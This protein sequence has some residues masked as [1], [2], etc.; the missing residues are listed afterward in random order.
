MPIEVHELRVPT[1]GPEGQAWELATTIYLPPPLA[2]ASGSNM[3][4]L[5]PGGGYGRG[6]F[7]LPV[8]GGSQALYHAG[9]GSIVVAV[10]PLG[11]GDSSA[12]EDASAG[13]ATAALN[14]A[15]TFISEGL[16]GGT[17]LPGLGPVA[18]GAAVGAGQSLGGH[19]LVATQAEYEPFAGIALLG[20]SMVGTR[21][22]LASGGST[23][24]TSEA[25]FKYVFH[26][27]E[28]PQ[29]DPTVAQT[30]LAGLA[31]VDVAI[32]LPVRHGD[33][34][35]ASRS[36]PSYVVELIDASA[37]K[38]GEV[39]GFVLVA[40]GERDVTGPLEEEAA[41]F[42]SAKGVGTFL[43]SEAAHMHNFAPSRELL[44]KQV[45][46]FVHHSTTAGRRTQSEAYMGRF[47]SDA[48]EEESADA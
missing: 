19:L 17:L 6:Y 14:A 47:S 22:P 39:T 41:T 33:A 12:A 36:F 28:V 34:S 24:S 42:T 18:F 11:V 2:L 29:V 13:A 4:V 5:L 10:D 37:A 27:G 45:D 31:G 1:P 44:W 21:F 40:A 30:D 38:A 20:S 16:R 3:L 48:D 15:V 8:P 9:R 43:L 7:D 25:D 23:E 46:R 32:G 26:W 35:W